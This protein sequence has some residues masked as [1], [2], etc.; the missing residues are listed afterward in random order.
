MSGAESAASPADPRGGVCATTEPHE[1]APTA[2]PALA[3]INRGVAELRE[4]D[5]RQGAERRWLGRPLGLALSAADE[6]CCVIRGARRCRHVHRAR[7]TEATNDA[8]KEATQGEGSARLIAS[9]RRPEGGAAG[10]GRGGD[11]P[12]CIRLRYKEGRARIRGDQSRSMAPG[13]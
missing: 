9:A 8:N 13:W 10:D 7:T 4:R 11:A 1:M 6:C 2:G 3:Q 12:G 5:E